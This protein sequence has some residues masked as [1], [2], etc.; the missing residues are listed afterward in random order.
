MGVK[1]S[2]KTLKTERIQYP[3]L[4][5]PA[6]FDS[7][8]NW[9][10]CDTIN[11][12]RDQSACGS[13]WAFGAA[14]AIS[15]R[16]CTFGGPKN[17]SIAANDLLACCSSCGMGCSGG[18]PIAAWQSWVQNGLVDNFCDPYPFPHCEHHVHPAHPH[19]PACPKQ[20]YPSPQCVQTCKDGKSWSGSKHFGSKAYS[21]FGEADYKTE[22]FQHGP[23]EVAFTV[24]EDFPT[25]KGGVYKHTTGGALGGHAVKVVGWGELN[26]TPYWKVANSWNQDWG[27]EGFFLILRGVDEC[28]IET[29]GAAGTPKL[30]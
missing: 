27:V 22:L 19:Y 4:D 24:Y 18:E 28:G 20:E 15:D 8:K 17:L 21:V 12:I 16:Y 30:S 14:E 13:C 9:P 5:L 23:F 10:T 3:K 29:S 26:G 25:Y 2:A 7:A 1:T 6:E 11:M